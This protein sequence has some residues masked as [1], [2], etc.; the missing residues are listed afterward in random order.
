MTLE[1]RGKVSGGNAG[2]IAAGGTL[3]DS[4]AAVVAAAKRGDAQAFEKLVERYEGRIFRLAQNIMQNRE[5]AEDVSQEAFVQ[6][7]QHLDKFQGDSRFST[8]LTRI[9]INQALMKLRKKRR[10]KE[11]SLDEPVEED[12]PVPVQLVDWG[13]TPEQRY[14]QREMQRILSE[15]IAGLRPMF[16]A[17]FQLRDIEEFS[18]EETA[19][20]LGL[21]IPAV[22]ARAV[23]AR[24]QLR[25]ALDRH[26]RR[27]EM[28]QSAGD[29]ARQGTMV[30]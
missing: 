8:W 18:T 24:L 22:K 23:R 1:L 25:E 19:Q 2:I 15:A 11:F 29:E 6:A 26:F 20:A 10:V 17:V 14:S 27:P 4:E 28:M 9:A 3:P 7:F 16:R 30:Q 13:P 5:D 21:S 12:L